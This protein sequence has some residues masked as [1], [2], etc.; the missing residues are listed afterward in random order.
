VLELLPVPPLED[1]LAQ[2]EQDTRLAGG[3]GG[4]RRGFRGFC[5]FRGFRG[6]DLTARP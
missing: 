4:G 5:G 3:F 6:G 1:D 2:L